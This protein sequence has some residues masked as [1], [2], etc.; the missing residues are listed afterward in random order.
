MLAFAQIAAGDLNVPFICQ[1][2]PTLLVL[3][4]EFEARPIQVVGLHAAFRRQGGRKQGVKSAPADP[5]DA[6]ILADQN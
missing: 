4:D 1:L 5:H 2:P 3:R 6:S